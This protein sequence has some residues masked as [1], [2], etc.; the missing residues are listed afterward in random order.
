MYLEFLYIITDYFCIL[1]KRS[2]T[3]EWGI[4]FMLGI[5]SGV[6][7]LIYN[8]T[9]LYNIIQN[10]IPII[11]T[12]LGFTLAALTLFLTGNSKMEDAKSYITAREIEGEKISLYRFVVISYSYLILLE[13]LLCIG[14]YIATLFPY[15]SN[16]YICTI[17]NTAFIILMFNAFF[18]TMR[19]ITD[20]Y[21]IITK[22]D[23]GGN[24]IQPK[25]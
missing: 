12:L 16:L 23:N 15:I 4:P 11:T 6:L 9:V 24:N 14:F 22:E 3:Y 10:A 25:S 19:S 2:A 13:T 8:N 5:T 18:S 1:D 17:A 20:L 21:F 7:S